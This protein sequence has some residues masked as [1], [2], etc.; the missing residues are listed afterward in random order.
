[1]DINKLKDIENSTI[2]GFK[3]KDSFAYDRCYNRVCA[4]L[5]ECEVFKT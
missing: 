3:Y 5:Q 1:M 2:E 4:R